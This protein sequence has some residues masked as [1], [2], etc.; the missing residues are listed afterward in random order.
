MT[1]LN[2]KMINMTWLNENMI[3][4][5]AENWLLYI[6]SGSTTTNKCVVPLSHEWW[7]LSH[8]YES[9]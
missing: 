7:V 4:F 2:E 1:C 5:I 6:K 9:H 8:K 3:E